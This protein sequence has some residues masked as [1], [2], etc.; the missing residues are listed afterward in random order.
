MHQ[1]GLRYQRARPSI[2]MAATRSGHRPW[3]KRPP[4]RQV[5]VAASALANVT[6][7]KA[8]LSSSFFTSVSS[9]IHPTSVEWYT[10]VPRP[11]PCRRE[12]TRWSYKQPI[13][14]F[15]QRNEWCAI[16]QRHYRRSIRGYA[17]IEPI[18]WHVHNT[19]RTARRVAA[20]R[21]WAIDP[22]QRRWARRKRRN[23]GY[24]LARLTAP[25]FVVSANRV[26]RSIR[27][28]AFFGS[29]C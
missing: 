14:L 6:I 29:L 7:S 5:M 28:N 20:H 16:N 10:S 8:A 1:T 22:T 13:T 23:Y 11:R 15:L 4:M 12:V 26:L 24:S 27:V 18:G 21:V 17:N 19:H 2:P 9:E 25:I 3:Y